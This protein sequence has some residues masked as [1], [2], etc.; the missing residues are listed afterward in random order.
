MSSHDSHLRDDITDVPGIQVGSAHDLNAKTGVT[1]ILPPPKGAL[2]GL[3]VG[4]KRTVDSSDGFPERQPR[5]GQGPR[6]SLCGGSA[7]GL[8][9]AGGV[10]MKLEEWASACGGREDNPH[11]AGC[12]HL[13]SD[14][15]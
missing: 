11:C 13:R 3:Y 5:G 15:G 14:S 6:I 9:A 8:D 7:R 12:C 10:L 4:G 2:A 1:V